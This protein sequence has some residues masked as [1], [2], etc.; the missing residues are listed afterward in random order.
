[1]KTSLPLLA[2]ALAASLAVG[3]PI[4]G[5]SSGARAQDAPKGD[6]VH[7]RQVFMAIG[8]YQCH[9][10]QGATG[11]PGG[12]LAPDPLNFEAV[13]GQLRHPRGRMPVYTPVIASD[14]DVADIYA[15]LKSQP[16]P[17]K[18]ADIPLLQQY[19]P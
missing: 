7:G 2:A 10:W 11:G 8:C 14:Q 5:F 3:A 13:M 9:G 17:K 1:M 12:R 6:P 15:Y 16:E 4:A 19:G 18:V